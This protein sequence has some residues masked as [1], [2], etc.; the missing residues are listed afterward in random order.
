LL[1]NLSGDYLTK[2]EFVNQNLE[3]FKA[4]TLAGNYDNYSPLSIFNFFQD[5]EERSRQRLSSSLQK[6][7]QFMKNAQFHSFKKLDQGMVSR[8]MLKKKNLHS[9]QTT[10]FIKYLF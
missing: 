6:T 10:S 9:I 2:T 4:L 7:K 3:T 8:V 5:Q 1:D